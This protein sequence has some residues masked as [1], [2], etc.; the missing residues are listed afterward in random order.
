M[1]GF[2]KKSEAFLKHLKRNGGFCQQYETFW[3]ILRF[4]KDIFREVEAFYY[5]R[6]A[7][8]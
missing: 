6:E 1:W 3:T 5:K 8:F 7:F 4:L 2:F